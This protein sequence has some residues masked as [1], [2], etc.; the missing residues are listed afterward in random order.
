MT[1]FEKMPNRINTEK[2][3]PEKNKIT[4]TTVTILVMGVSIMMGMTLDDQCIPQ[5]S[6]DRSKK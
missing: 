6:P 1:G 5:Q 2:A 3:M 4:V